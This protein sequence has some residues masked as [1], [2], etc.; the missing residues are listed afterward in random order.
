MTTSPPATDPWGTTSWDRTPPRPGLVWMRPKDLCSNPRFV[1]GG[2][3]RTDICQGA[4]GDCWLLAAIASLT[5]HEQ[6][7][8][9]VVP[10]GQSFEESYAGIFHFQ[11]RSISSLSVNV[12]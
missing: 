5:L 8:A 9:R 3:T 10:P 4:L 11:V 2:A 6:I 1:A 7:L 12:W